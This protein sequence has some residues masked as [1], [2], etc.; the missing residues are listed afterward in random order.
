MSR[1]LHRNSMMQALTE[2]N[3]EFLSVNCCETAEGT[4]SNNLA[5]VDLKSTQETVSCTALK[6]Q[7]ESVYPAT[8]ERNFW[9][10][11]VLG[12][13]RYISFKNTDGTKLVLSGSRIF[14]EFR[15]AK[16]RVYLLDYERNMEA[17]VDAIWSIVVIIVFY[18]G[19]ESNSETV[20]QPKMAE[21]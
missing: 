18:L 3:T 16:D 10:C 12:H 1:I 11:N 13:R 4:T 2:G 6:P 19:I 21:K 15:Y 8:V 7:V 14:L 17:H 5:N 9:K 20:D